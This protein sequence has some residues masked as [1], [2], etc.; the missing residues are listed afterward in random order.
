[1][2]LDKIFLQSARRQD[3]KDLNVVFEYIDEMY[4]CTNL[5]S[6]NV[7]RND[8]LINDN[9]TVKKLGEAGQP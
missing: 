6:R 5:M 9:A 4:K 2:Y 1:M 3:K 8:Q 7:E